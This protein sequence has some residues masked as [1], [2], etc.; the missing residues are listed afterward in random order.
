MELLQKNT[1]PRL[2]LVCILLLSW[3]S[4][5]KSQTASS[6]YKVDLKTPNKLLRHIVLLE[7][8][9]TATAQDIATV[10][11]AFSTLPTIIK[12]IRDFEWGLNNSPENLNDGFTHSFLV[13]FLS[14]VDRDSYLPHPAHLDFVAILKPHLKKVLVLDYWTNN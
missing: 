10:E 12:E 4:L 1:A 5:V 6:T 14:E 7:F 2:V 9:E 8:N 3:S 13:T 11:K